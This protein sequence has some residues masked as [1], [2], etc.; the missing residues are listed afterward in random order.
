MC[1]CY[2][3]MCF[4]YSG[5]FNK[6]GSDYRAYP[7]TNASDGPVMDSKPGMSLEGDFT[8]LYL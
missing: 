5:L 2:P 6:G 3:P 8:L 4:C 7:A 1:F